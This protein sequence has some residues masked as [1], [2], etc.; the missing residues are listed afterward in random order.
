MGRKVRRYKPRSGIEVD[1]EEQMNRL[2]QLRKMPKSDSGV[3][4]HSASAGMMSGARFRRV[5]AQLNH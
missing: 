5:A 3:S 2:W 1:A 4:R